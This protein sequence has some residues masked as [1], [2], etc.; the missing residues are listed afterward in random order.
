MTYMEGVQVD[1]QKLATDWAVLETVE[2]Y[3]NVIIR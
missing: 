2:D 3:E 1:F